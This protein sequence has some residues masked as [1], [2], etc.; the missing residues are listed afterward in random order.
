M[1]DVK[2]VRFQRDQVS[3]IAGICNNVLSSSNE[4]LLFFG[5]CTLDDSGI[6]SK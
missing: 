6:F 4:L 2:S 3:E 1:S 5:I